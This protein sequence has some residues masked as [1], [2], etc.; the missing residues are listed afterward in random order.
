MQELPIDI[1]EVDQLFH[2]SDIHIRNFKRH[3]EYNQIFQRLYEEI[4]NRKTDNSLIVVTG[5]VV[6]SKADMSPE[7]VEEVRKFLS[8]LG[9]RL[10]TILIPGNHDMLSSNPDR[11]DA[12][13]P[14]VKA[15][16]HSNIYYLF[17]TG[18][19]E[20]GDVVFS[21]MNFMDDPEN[22]IPASEIPDDKRKIALFH[23][24][25]DRAKTEYGYTLTN[26]DVDASMFVGFDQ[27]LLGDIHKRQ[28]VSEHRVEEMKV[29]K[30]E[31]DKYLNA[32]WEVVD[33]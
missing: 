2:I 3:K 4:D 26:D 29:P 25:V 16:D 11:L 8:S 23:D 32:G 31:A 21:H 10:P 28:Q 13:S 9:D 15:M 5:D 18:L 1:D 22:Y 17:E 27:A 19:Y 7:L 6:H 24:V 20:V 33:E 12:L 30:S 14:I